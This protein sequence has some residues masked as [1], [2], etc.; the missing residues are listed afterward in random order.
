MIKSAYTVQPFTAVAL[1]VFEC[2]R[3]ELVDAISDSSVGLYCT[4]TLKELASNAVLKLY[5]D[6]DDP[7]IKSIMNE[8]RAI[9]NGQRPELRFIYSESYES[10]LV[11]TNGTEIS[12]PNKNI[13]SLEEPYPSRFF[14][15]CIKWINNGRLCPSVPVLMDI[16]N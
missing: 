4:H 1:K 12:I 16:E 15:Y 2:T 7:Q 9:D 5:T 6:Y 11:L 8:L 14:A 10:K 3:G 13:L